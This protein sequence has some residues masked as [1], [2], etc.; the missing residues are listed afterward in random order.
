MRV[1]KAKAEANRERVVEAAATL[2]RANGLDGVGVAALAEAA[3]L[4]HGAVYSHFAS[5]DA[6]AAAAVDAAMR[7]SLADWQ[8]LTDGLAGDDAFVKLLKVYVSRSHRDRPERGCAIAALGAQ[9]GRGGEPLQEAFAQGVRDLV[10]VVA[11]VSPGDTATARREA[12]TLRVA[13]MIGAV[14]MA[15]ASASDSRL[16]EDILRIVRRRLGA[17]QV[18]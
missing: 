11:Q 4:T 13:A 14:V 17:G 18:A 10:D 12:A 5:K 16:S 3:G 8:A 7:Q 15:R 6:L 1:S 2:L 9:A